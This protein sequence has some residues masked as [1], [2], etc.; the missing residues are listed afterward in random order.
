MARLFIYGSL[1]PGG[2]NEHVLAPLEG[3]WEPAT[4]KGR[5]VE[6]G[7]GAALG[8]PGLVLDSDGELVAGQLFTS[9]ALTDIWQE[10]DEF[11]GD[12][13]A[14]VTAPVSLENGTRVDAFVYVLQDKSDKRIELSPKFS[15]DNGLS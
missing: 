7:W 12:Q 11:E 6:E 2:T 4:I 13:Y 8:Y 10:L 14:R 9:P 3:K 1:Q 15:T 5:L